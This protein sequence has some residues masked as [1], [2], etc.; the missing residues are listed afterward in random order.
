MKGLIVLMEPWAQ[1]GNRKKKWGSNFHWGGKI[2][3]RTRVWE[4]G[5]LMTRRWG[6]HPQVG[7]PK[8]ENKEMQ[9]K[10]KKVSR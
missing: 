2:G 8:K 6:V 7:K 3:V 4:G 5:Q 10:R 1:R 9:K